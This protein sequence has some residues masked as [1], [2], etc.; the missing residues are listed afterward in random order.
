MKSPHRTASD[1]LNWY[2]ELASAN[3][4]LP[5]WL[6]MIFLIAGLVGMTVGLIGFVV[7]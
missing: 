4:T 3:A 5:V 7:G 1:E 2:R 6:L